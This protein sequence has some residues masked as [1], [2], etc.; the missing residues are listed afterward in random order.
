MDLALFTAIR[1][2]FSPTDLEEHAL[3]EFLN[4]AQYTETHGSSG[5]PASPGPRGAR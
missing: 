4:L 2:V 1:E 3:V 5:G